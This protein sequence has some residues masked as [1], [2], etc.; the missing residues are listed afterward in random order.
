LQQVTDFID[1]HLEQ[2]IALSELATII[3]MSSS[4]FSSLFKQSIGL[5]PYQYVIQRRIEQAKQ[6]LQQG[7]L[8]I[9][10]IAYSL[11]FSHQSHLSGHFK[12]LVESHRKHF[13]KG[14]KLDFSH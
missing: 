8:S 9:A 12:R 14:C 10:D 2:D 7:K 3:Q 1:Q 5:T 4:Y 6:L 13:C 11:S